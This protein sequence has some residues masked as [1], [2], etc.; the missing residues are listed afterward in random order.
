MTP[1]D[2]RHGTNAGWHAHHKDGEPACQ[3]CRN[4]MGRL[5]KRNR[6]LEVTGQPQTVPKLGIVRR[7]RALQALGWTLNQIAD[8]AGI[9]ARTVKDPLYRG[10]VCY[11]TT[12]EAI[13]RAYRMLSMKLPREVTTQEKRDASYSRG[14]AKRRGWPPPLAWDDIDDPDETPQVAAYQPRNIRDSYR[15]DDYDESVVLRILDGERLPATRAEREEAMRRWLAMG[16]TEKSLC[17]IHGWKEG[18]YSTRR[19][20]AA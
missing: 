19:E 9:P 7:I 15:S 18:R 4:A 2:P 13:D 11:R 16:R 8:A 6:F 3:P 17:A 10:E 1:D 20:P 5:R 12:A 14:I